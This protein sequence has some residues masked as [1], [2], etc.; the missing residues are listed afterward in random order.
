MGAQGRPQLIP[1]S[2][3]VVR[4]G[5]RPG[6][7][8]CDL[9]IP[10]KIRSRLCLQIKKISFDHHLFDLYKG[11]VPFLQ[12]VIFIPHAAILHEGLFKK[13]PWH[14]F[15]PWYL[16]DSTSGLFVL[17]NQNEAETYMPVEERDW[18]IPQD[19]GPARKSSLRQS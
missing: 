2:L 14:W 11:E 19:A 3:P 9:Q 17:E 6:V 18:K 7:A 12:K 5:A 1:S 4:G 13:T 15:L 16:L 8:P 10:V